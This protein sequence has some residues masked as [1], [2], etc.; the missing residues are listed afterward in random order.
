MSP[1]A[2]PAFTAQL[3]SLA[4][5]PAPRF[6]VFTS[7]WC[8]DCVRAAPAVRRAV[9][10]SG[11]SVLEV[12]VGDRGEWRDATHPLRVDP[13]LQ[14]TG[15]PTLFKWELNGPGERLGK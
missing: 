8:P 10:R 12:D 13:T 6:I 11:G 1:F 3:Q 5:Q 7:S 4:A 14:L 9:A 2:L 15:V